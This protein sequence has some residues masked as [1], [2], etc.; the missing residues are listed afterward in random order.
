MNLAVNENS[1]FQVKAIANSKLESLESWLKAN[2]ASEKVMRAQ[3]LWDLE[4][5]KE[6]PEDFNP[7]IQTP[8]IPDGSP[9]GSFE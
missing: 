7:F 4:R 5:F 3:F 2:M 6:N 9:I 1:I 8:K